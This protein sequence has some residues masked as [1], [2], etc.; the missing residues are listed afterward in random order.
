M[1]TMSFRPPDQQPPGG[2]K[3]KLRETGGTVEGEDFSDFLA[4]VNDMLVPN[5]FQRV[6][7]DELLDRV[8]HAQHEK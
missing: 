8:Y 7:G 4:K 3:I 1:G 6:T 5:G 2:W